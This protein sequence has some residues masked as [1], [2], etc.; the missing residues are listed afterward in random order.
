MK[1][2]GLDLGSQ[3]TGICILELTEQ[4]PKLIYEITVKSTQKKVSKR[5]LFIANN[6]EKILKQYQPKLACLETPFHGMDVRAL[7]VLS[8]VRGVALV[9]LERLGVQSVDLSPQEIKKT[10]TGYGHATKDQVE[11]MMLGLLGHKKFSSQDA[12]DAAAVA[13]AGMLYFEKQRKFREATS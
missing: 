2:V 6:L 12:S 13:Y 10:I 9:V 8:Q 4:S 1:C 7:S 11:K 5:L 3:V